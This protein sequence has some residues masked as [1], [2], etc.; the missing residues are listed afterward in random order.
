MNF[1]DILYKVFPFVCNS[2]SI[3]IKNVYMFQRRKY[4]NLIYQNNNQNSLKAI[5]I[6]YLI[7][8]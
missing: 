1:K 3:P 8:Y 2:K 4:F 6:L 5:Y 7:K